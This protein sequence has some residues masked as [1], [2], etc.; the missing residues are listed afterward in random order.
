VLSARNDDTQRLAYLAT[1]A[2]PQDP[3]PVPMEPVG[4]LTIGCRQYADRLGE[5]GFEVAKSTVQAILV[6]TGWGAAL[7]LDPPMR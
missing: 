7:S 4:E 5:R 1:A 3:E 2:Q 6:A